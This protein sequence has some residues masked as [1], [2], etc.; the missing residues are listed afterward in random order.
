MDEYLPSLPSASGMK[1]ISYLKL[2]SQ[3]KLEFSL[4]LSSKNGILSILIS[5]WPDK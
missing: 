3:V 4:F 1:V 2:I 5:S